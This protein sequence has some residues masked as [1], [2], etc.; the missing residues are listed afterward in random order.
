MF[1][2]FIA[3]RSVACLTS[4]F[5]SDVRFA[6]S[7]CFF[8]FKGMIKIQFNFFW[9]EYLIKLLILRET[10][11]KLN[12]LCALSSLWAKYWDSFHSSDNSFA[13]AQGCLRASESIALFTAT[14]VMSVLKRWCVLTTQVIN[15]SYRFR[16]IRRHLKVRD[17]SEWDVV[18]FIA[19]WSL[20]LT[21]DALE[22][23]FEAT[24]LP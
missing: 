15:F 17:V 12:L 16:I 19:V 5:H 3:T 18:K 22:I 4:R 10:L 24:L 7:F 2:Y 14:G 11:A 6:Y 13:S 23:I 8:L 20:L 9:T 1:P 21:A